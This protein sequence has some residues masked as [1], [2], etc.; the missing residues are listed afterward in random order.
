MALM[1]DKEAP[2]VSFVIPVRNDAHGLA[3]CLRSIRNS[4]S[5]AGVPTECIVVDN[6]SVDESA[7]VAR[8]A[9]CDVL[10]IPGVRVGELRNRGSQRARGAMLAFVDADHELD[11]GWVAAA[12]DAGR[13]HPF[14]ATGAAY[15]APAAGTWVQR[16]YDGLRAHPA[17]VRPVEWLGSGNL[18]VDQALFERVG[19]FDAT[20]EACEDVDFSRRVHSAGAE[21]WSDA[22]LISIHHGDPATLGALFRSELWRGRNNVRVSARGA[23]TLQTLPSVLIPIGQ[24]LLLGISAVLLAV[25]RPLFALAA[26]AL[27]IVPSMARAFRIVSRA[28]VPWVHAIAVAVVYDVARAFALISRTSHR[29]AAQPAPI[30]AD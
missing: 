1:S 24:L 10:V 23:L 11:A 28:A 29:R 3:R 13:S 27:I 5:S 8:E 17:G 9:G 30:T 26:L 4:A 6:G 14:A 21:V 19:G 12:I 2:A 16:A 18:L 7:Q 15:R 25:Q 20:L 22:R